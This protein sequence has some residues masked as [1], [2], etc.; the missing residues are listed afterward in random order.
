MRQTKVIVSRAEEHLSWSC[1]EMS[2]H[3]K[4]FHVVDSSRCGWGRRRAMLRELFVLHSCRH[5]RGCRN[6]CWYIDIG[7]AV[8]QTHSISKSNEIVYHNTSLAAR[9]F[10]QLLVAHW[11]LFASGCCTAH[12]GAA[13]AIRCRQRQLSSVYCW[14]VCFCRRCRH[15][16]THTP[17][18]HEPAILAAMSVMH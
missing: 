5:R 10:L 14:Y 17:C 12:C 8:A 11:A 13:A 6:S 2:V 7:A 9:S 1:K 15:T 3:T 4:C 16:H 18:A